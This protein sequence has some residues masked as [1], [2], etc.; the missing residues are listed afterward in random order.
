MPVAAGGVPVHAELHEAQ[1]NKGALAA[2]VTGRAAAPPRHRNA[3]PVPL[4]ADRMYDGDDWRD[5]LP[6]L[7]DDLVCPHRCDR[8][9]PVRQD[10]RRLRRHRRRWAVERAVAWLKAERRPCVRHERK[11][12]PFLALAQLKRAPICLAHF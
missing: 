7:G 10:G 12:E 8:V 1:R 6:A 4:L 11:P 2:G 5:D 3:R 9:R